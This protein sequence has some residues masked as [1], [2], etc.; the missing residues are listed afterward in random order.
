MIGKSLGAVGGWALHVL[1]RWGES[2]LLFVRTLGVTFRPPFYFR[3][4]IYQIESIG[5]N[6]LPVVLLTSAFTGLVLALQIFSGFARFGAESMTGTVV[7]YSIVRELGPV[8]VGLMVAGRAGAAMAAELGTMR[9]TQ[10]IDA[11]YAL[12]ADPVRYLIVPRFWA[13][14]IALPLLVSLGDFIAIWASYALTVWV[15]GANPVV[16]WDSMFDF[17]ELWDFYSGLIKATVF[18]GIIAFVAS[19]EGFT[20][21]GGAR[22]VGGATTRAV[23]GA[24]S[25]ILAA[26]YF[27]T[28][29]VV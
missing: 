19:F 15:L 18:G 21:R 17:M 3:N 5:I 4:F 2:A 22:G 7:G 24:A 10:Q 13:G 14:V 26:N 16:Y 25:L 9:V 1:G 12:S 11:L 6:S 29:L 8:L 23:V 28:Y 20:A 27:I